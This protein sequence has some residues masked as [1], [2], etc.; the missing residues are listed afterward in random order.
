MLSWSAHCAL[1]WGVQE[2]VS[3]ATDLIKQQIDC[4]PAIT[5]IAEHG[6][7]IVVF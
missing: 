1:H 3:N 6:K 2:I 4:G 5:A 7:A